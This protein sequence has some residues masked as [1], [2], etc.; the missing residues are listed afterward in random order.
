MDVAKMDGKEE[1]MHLFIHL[2]DIYGTLAI[3]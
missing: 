3:V 1:I 2:I